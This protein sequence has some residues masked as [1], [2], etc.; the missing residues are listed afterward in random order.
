MQVKKKHIVIALAS[1][2]VLLGGAAAAGFV[3]MNNVVTPYEKVI[4][5]GVIIEDINLSGK[6]KEEAFNLI[7]QKYGDEVLKKKVNIKGANRTYTIDYSKLNAKYNT[8]ETVNEAF[9]YGKN[10]GIFEKYKHIKKPVEKKIEL[11]FTYD[12]KPI[13][14][15]A[16]GMTKE[17]D[18]APVNASIKMVG[19]GKFS[20]TPEEPGAK[21]DTEKLVQD[22][23]NVINGKLT[24][25]VEV[26]AKIDNVQA[27][28]TKD[29]LSKVNTKISSFTTNFASSNANRINNISLATKS[30]NGKLLL[31]G[32]SFSFND[33]VGQRTTARG[34]KEAGVI[35][36]NKLD[37]GVGGGICQV[38]T[39]LYNAVMK[40]NINYT[41]RRHHSL[42]SSYIAPGLDATVSYGSIDYKFKNTLQYPIYIEG[43]TSGKN[44]TFNI[45]SDSSLAKRTYDL[46]SEVYGTITPNIKYIDD[47]NMYEG[48]KEVVEKPSTGYK[49]RVYRSTYENGK[50]ISKEKLYEET[51]R[52]IDG[53]TKRGTKK[54]PAAP[55][56]SKPSTPS[57]PSTPEAAGG[58]QQNPPA[59]EAQ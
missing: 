47:P 2:V 8:E 29:I 31:P 11:K 39:T 19:R 44:V 20:I 16:A 33:V 37:S 6:T 4:L 21:L 49:V 43:Y 53:V 52:K 5:P 14:E 34:Y 42:A 18:K 59:A 1:T 13:K 56:P 55:T 40:A 30:I 7:Q 24:G 38:S 41:E 35:I 48:E 3:H 22:I 28:V 15:L 50:L 27:S 51:Y 57:T 12:E 9:I 45:Y 58:N 26:A 54:K 17:I 46:V 25:D 10:H 36:N 23:N 32:E